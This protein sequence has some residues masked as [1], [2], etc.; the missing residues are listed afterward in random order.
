MKMHLQMLRTRQETEWH[1]KHYYFIDYLIGVCCF[2]Y[3][4]YPDR[5]SQFSD[6]YVPQIDVQHKGYVEDPGHQR[7]VPSSGYYQG[8]IAQ[9]EM[10]WNG[11][12]Q[13]IQAPMQNNRGW[14]F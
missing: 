2:S 10:F 3:P 7:S 6:H 14:S 8:N 11:Y 4:V 1:S 9:N 12:D 13:R 5:G